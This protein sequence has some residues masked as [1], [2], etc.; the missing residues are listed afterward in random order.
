[1]L[2][3]RKRQRMNEGQ[4][5]LS[6][7]D[8]SPSWFPHPFIA[9]QIQ[10]VVH[11]LKSDAKFHPKNSQGFGLF[12]GKAGDE[13]GGVASGCKR[14]CG[15]S[16][17]DGEVIL[18]RCG[19]IQHVVELM[20]LRDGD[21]G[22]ASSD[23]RD[24]LFA[25]SASQS[26]T[27]HEQ[28][29][30]RNNGLGLTGLGVD[31][32]NA[33]AMT[34]VVVDIVMH[35]GGRVDEFKRQ[36]EG[37]DLFLLRPSSEFVSEKKQQ[38][39]EAFSSRI[40]N[41][42]CFKSNFARPS[43]DLFVDEPLEFV[44]HFF[45]HALERGGE[46]FD[47]AAHTR[48]TTVGFLTNRPRPQA[49]GGDLRR[50]ERMDEQERLVVL[51]TSNRD[52]GVRHQIERTVHTHGRL[53]DMRMK[54]L[55]HLETAIEALREGHGDIVAMSA[56]DWENHAVDGLI[57]AGVLPRKEPTWVLV[58]PDK[59]EYL[60][61]ESVVMCD[62]ELLRRQ[63]RRMRSDLVLMS[64]EELIA[65][66]GHQ[67]TFASLDVDEQWPWIEERMKQ[68]EF[69]GFIVPRSIHAGHRMKSR[70]HT[71]GL[72]RDQSES[73][74]ERFVPPPLHGFTLLVARHG[75]PKGSL[76]EMVDPSAELA[77]R[78]ESA[79]LESLDPV[80]HPITGMYVE[81]RKIS[82]FLKKATN[83]GDETLLNTL[84]DPN[85]K[86]GVYKAGPRVEL[87]I[88]T[89]N[90]SG[91]VTAACERIVLPEDSHVGMVNLLREFMELVNLMTSEH[92]STK[93][94][95][96]GLPASF[97]EPRPAMMRLSEEE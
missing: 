75:F 25:V 9:S 24:D 67:E 57:I 7:V 58:G 96:P 60:L 39:A 34:S 2:A 41:A 40:E 85:K 76:R 46:D 66:L 62:H 64:K 88:E 20:K 5:H 92:E 14:S 94:N 45:A 18:W 32:G 37:H 79:M 71:L 44:V 93:R 77:Y 89:L 48:L 38:G 23:H 81:Q 17:D 36:S 35:Q 8:I 27:V 52:D 11:E 49:V 22:T 70:R 78:L 68:G 56:F 90:P 30:A 1:M 51:T 59:P 65:H 84:V 83:E 26:E 61:P 31:G 80:Y 47:I 29:V 15:L 19:Q 73:E 10:K 50:G 53:R 95:I 87:L 33:P 13:A 63:T 21:V 54:Q 43:F 6:F 3:V 69:A 42:T 16:T 28:P 74:R 72:Q 86:K 82:T 12:F 91:T 55:P 4:C 97:S